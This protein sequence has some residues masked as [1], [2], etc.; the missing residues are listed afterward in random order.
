M[1]YEETDKS[2]N[3]KIVY[4]QCIEWLNVYFK[5][6]DCVF[7]VF[8]LVQRKTIVFWEVLKTA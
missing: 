6:A 4:E 5:Y 1:K 2:E 8:N 7:I 3:P